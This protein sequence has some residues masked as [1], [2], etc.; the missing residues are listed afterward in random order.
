MSKPED[1]FE[2]PAK[3]TVEK[4]FSPPLESEEETKE[5]PKGGDVEKLPHIATSASGGENSSDKKE[6]TLWEL[7]D[8]IP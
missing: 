7:E 8:E 5:E 6:K 4:P 2:L 1:W 3:K